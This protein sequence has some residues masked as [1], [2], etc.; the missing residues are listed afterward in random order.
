MDPALCRQY[1]VSFRIHRNVRNWLDL[2][3][4]TCKPVDLAPRLNIKRL[5]GVKINPR[6]MKLSEEGLLY[7]ILYSQVSLVMTQEQTNLPLTD[8]FNFGLA[9]NDWRERRVLITILLI[10]YQLTHISVQYTYTF[11]LGRPVMAMLLTSQWH[12]LTFGQKWM[13]PAGYYTVLSYICI[14]AQQRVN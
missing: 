14:P 4:P 8:Y 7:F 6:S 5:F 10:T 12:Y 2:K 9:Y 1:L 3:W 13:H 11:N